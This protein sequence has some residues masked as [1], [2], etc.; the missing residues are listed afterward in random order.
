MKKP[1]F[2]FF[3]HQKKTNLRCKQFNQI[4]MNQNVVKFLEFKGKNIVYLSANGTYWIAIKPVCEVLVV[5]YIR[6]YKNLRAD[7]ILGPEL[8]KQTMQVP[9]DQMRDYVC[10]PEEYIYGWIFS[11]RSE[12]KEL[13]EYKCECYHILY[14]HFHGI[15]TRRR[16]LIKERV[17]VT[18][19]RRT[20]EYELSQNDSFRKWEA[21]KA[22]EA[23]IGKQM[24]EAERGEIQ[25]E[26]DL[27]NQKNNK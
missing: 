17:I 8:S 23:R 13:Q 11:I 10:L 24:K 14:N 20:L 3:E 1:E 6:H 9:G 15:I 4:Y 26:L 5:D 18:N 25:E 27:F 22:S 7:Q 2:R 21:L 12:S 19:E 16:E